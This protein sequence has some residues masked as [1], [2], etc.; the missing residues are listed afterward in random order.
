ML[1]FFP[2]K[3]S[4]NRGLTGICQTGGGIAL[5]HV[6]RQGEGKPRLTFCDFLPGEMAEGQI[7]LREKCRQ[8]DLCS[9]NAVY[10]LEIGNYQ[11]LQVAPPEVPEAELREALR[12]QIRDLVDFPLEEAV[13]DFF[14][15]SRGHQREGARTAY[16]VV[17]RQA[18]VRQR[19]ALMEEARLEIQAIDIPELVLRNLA[20]LHPDAERGVAFLYFAAESGMIIVVRGREL[21]LAR[22]LPLGSA[23]LREGTENLESAIEVIALEIQRSFDFYE[24][25][26]AQQPIGSLLVAP[27]D[28]DDNDLLAGLRSALGIRVGTFDL[29]Q[30]LECPESLPEHPGR[31]LLAIGAALRTEQVSG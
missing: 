7:V 4:R 17:A 14:H 15:V 29:E 23:S 31:C 28:F 18:L 20:T 8:H 5:A 26:F 13:I 3:I 24:R 12:W 30:I 16:V 10:A 22:N 21:C 1:R 2:R 11:L 9:G 19:A 25:S 27:Q 6:V